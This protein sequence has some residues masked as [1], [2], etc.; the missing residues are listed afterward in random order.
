MNVEVIY[1]TQIKAALERAS[2]NVEVPDGSSAV[3]LL[4][5]LAEQ[6]GAAFGELV[7]ADD[8]ALLPAL[9]VCVGDAQLVDPAAR[10]L[11]EGDVVT[12]LSPISGG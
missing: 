4:Q 5:Q 12:L 2:E 8:G 6:H 7:F 10:P 9:I 3:D 11:A 1:T